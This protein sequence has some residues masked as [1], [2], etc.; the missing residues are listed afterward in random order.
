MADKIIRVLVDH[1]VNVDKQVLGQVP[2]VVGAGAAPVSSVAQQGRQFGFSGA[3]SAQFAVEQASR[4]LNATG[5]Q[6]L[7]NT[8]STLGRYTFLGARAL[9]GDV[10]AMATL[11]MSMAQKAIEQVRKQAEKQNEID[12]NFIKYGLINVEGTRISKNFFTGRQIYT[13]E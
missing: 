9:G 13:R 2:S 8:I 7:A 11:A 3:I 4:L 5:N 10:T 1:N 6:E 12:N